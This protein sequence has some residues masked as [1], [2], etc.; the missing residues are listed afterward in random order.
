M[1]I[2]ACA[3]LQFPTIYSSE[4]HAQ[5]PFDDFPVVISCEYKEMQHVY[6]LSRVTPEGMATYVSS[7]SMAGTISLDGKAKAVGGSNAGTCV[8]KTLA[9]LRASG[10][11]HDLKR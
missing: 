5:D 11:A 3:L 10:Q 8:G 1:P 7:D 4:A 6:Y 2:A 9:E